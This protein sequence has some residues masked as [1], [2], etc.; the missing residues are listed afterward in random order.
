[1]AS[2]GAR[3]PSGQREAKP[4]LHSKTGDD[5]AHRSTCGGSTIENPGL[6]HYRRRCLVARVEF[7]ERWGKNCSTVPPCKN[8]GRTTVPTNARRVRCA[9]STKRGSPARFAPPRL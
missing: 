5:T 8:F 2:P 1:M 7:V 9:E 6:P 3:N 4:V